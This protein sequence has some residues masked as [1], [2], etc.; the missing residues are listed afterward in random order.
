MKRNNPPTLIKCRKIR[1]KNSLLKIQS[2]FLQFP[3]KSSSKRRSSR[4]KTVLLTRAALYN[5]KI[6][7]IQLKITSKGLIS[8]KILIL[9]RKAVKN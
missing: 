8:S 4:L 7:S 6:Y 3:R 2:K 9:N 5:I 1:N